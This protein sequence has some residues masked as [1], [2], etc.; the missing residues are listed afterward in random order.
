MDVP[1]AFTIFPHD[2][3]TAPRA[4]GERFFDVRVWDQRPGG[5]HFGAWERPGDFAA[6]LRAAVSCSD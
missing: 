2:L 5:G 4:F 6:G 1:A 3:V